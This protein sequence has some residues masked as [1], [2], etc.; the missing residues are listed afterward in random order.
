MTSHFSLLVLF[1][2]LVSAVFA[3]LQR[4]TPQEQARL[5]LLLFA[6]FVIGAYL[7]G[8]LMYPLPLGR[9]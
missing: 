1:G 4:E 6:G 9:S 3:V 5:G 7:L 2:L 8:W